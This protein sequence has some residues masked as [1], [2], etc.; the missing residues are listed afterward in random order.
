MTF[1]LL[2]F[3]LYPA[4]IKSKHPRWDLAKD[5]SFK[6]LIKFEQLRRLLNDQDDWYNV[7]GSG[8][9]YQLEPPVLEEESYASNDSFDGL[10][11]ERMIHF[12]CKWLLW[13]RR[14]I[15]EMNTFR[16]S[17][18][19]FCDLLSLPHAVS[20]FGFCCVRA[21]VELRFE[22]ECKCTMVLLFRVIILK[23]FSVTHLNFAGIVCYNISYLVGRFKG[24]TLL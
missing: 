18:R 10:K 23:S 16:N 5:F 11:S 13:K 12:L 3:Y 19:K 6:A 24:F 1:F 4:N 2:S 17:F 7:L 21:Q 8:E 9:P 20:P 22:C 15:I 14:Y